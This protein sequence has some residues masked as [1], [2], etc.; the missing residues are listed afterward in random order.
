MLILCFLL[1]SLLLLLMTLVLITCLLPLRLCTLGLLHW[2]N[3]LCCCCV[4]HSVVSYSLQPHGLQPTRLL[5]SMEFSRQEYWSGLPSLLQ[6]TSLMQ[7]LNPGLLH[8]RQSIYHLS[9]QG[10]PWY[11]YFQRHSLCV[12]F[13]V[14][15]IL[16]YMLVCNLPF[17]FI[18]GE[19]L[20]SLE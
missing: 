6:G 16:L 14:N 1:H 15:G 10:S 11:I 9:H 5:L 18:S 3:L 4:S 12:C 13:S 19:H 8:N 7:G 17:Y 20:A 2:L